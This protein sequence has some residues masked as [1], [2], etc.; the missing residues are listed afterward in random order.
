MVQMKCLERVVGADAVTCGLSGKTSALGGFIRGV[1]TG[2]I[3][4]DHEV[5]VL[6]TWDNEEFRHGCVVMKSEWSRIL[7]AAKLG[8]FLLA[9]EPVCQSYAQRTPS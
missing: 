5:I 7:C 8:I 6:L 9:V 1:T 3:S 2:Y 4:S